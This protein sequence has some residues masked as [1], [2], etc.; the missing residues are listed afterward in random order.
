MEPYISRPRFRPLLYPSVESA[1]RCL[2]HSPSIGD[3]P[4]PSHSFLLRP[5]NFVDT[6]TLAYI[7][8]HTL[9]HS[10]TLFLKKTSRSALEFFAALT[11]CGGGDCQIYA[12]RKEKEGKERVGG[13][14]RT[15]GKEEEGVGGF[16]LLLRKSDSRGGEGGG[17]RGGFRFGG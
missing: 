10:E 15:E 3:P 12:K 9:A 14:R 5:A 7:V 11:A 2:F 6:H 16:L 4:T 8:Q 17:G 1:H 13:K